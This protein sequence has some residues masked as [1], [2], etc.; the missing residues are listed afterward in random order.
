MKNV[1]RSIEKHRAGVKCSSLFDIRP[2]QQPA[3][4]IVHGLYFDSRFAHNQALPIGKSNVNPISKPPLTFMCSKI[5]I[6]FVFDEK[7]TTG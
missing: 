3:F 2:S 6:L 5:L 1:T 7:I 4:L